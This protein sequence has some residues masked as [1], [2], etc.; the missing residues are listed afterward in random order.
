M[1]QLEELFKHHILK[2]ERVSSWKEALSI[3]CAPLIQ[4]G[5]ITTAYQTAMEESVK[6]HGPYMVIG[7]EFA[8][9]HAQP[10]EGVNEMGMS[11]LI[12]DEAVDLEGKPVKIFVILAAVDSSSHLECLK[13]LVS[14]LMEEDKLIWL[15]T[16]SVEEIEQLLRG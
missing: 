3:G 14:I 13:Q 15:Q 10:G 7:D 6:T 9:M 5:K 11:M 1:S 4:E 12:V 16:A 2:R 8:L